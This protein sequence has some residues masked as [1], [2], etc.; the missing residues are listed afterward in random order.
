[1]DEMDVYP[2]GIWQR[3]NEEVRTWLI[4]EFDHLK[5]FYS[6]AILENQAIISFIC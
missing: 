6:K 3:E 5:D 2:S 4:E 1:M